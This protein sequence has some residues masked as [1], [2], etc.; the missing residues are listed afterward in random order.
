MWQ[1]T[2]YETGSF[3]NE[4]LAGFCLVWLFSWDV[5]NFR[6]SKMIYVSRKKKEAKSKSCE[7]KNWISCIWLFLWWCGIH[8]TWAQFFLQ[9][10][11]FLNEPASHVFLI[12]HVKPSQQTFDRIL[13]W[14]VWSVGRVYTR[15]ISH[16]ISTLNLGNGGGKSHTKWFGGQIRPQGCFSGFAYVMGSGMTPRLMLGLLTFLTGH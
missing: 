9:N 12:P 13:L 7:K 2:V 4:T 15:A 6:C 1:Q 5:V 10:A 11:S 8:Y 14:I 3:R 16:F